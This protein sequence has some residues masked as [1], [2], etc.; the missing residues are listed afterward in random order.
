MNCGVVVVEKGDEEEQ[1][2]KRNDKNAWNILRRGN[3]KRRKMTLG[4]A[5]ADQLAGW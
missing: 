5:R 4:V 1:G 3:V 2:K